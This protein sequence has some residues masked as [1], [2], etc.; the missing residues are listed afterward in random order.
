VTIW[1]ERVLIGSESAPQ[2]LTTRSLAV[3]STVGCTV[4]EPFGDSHGG[5]SSH[6]PRAVIQ[7]VAKAIVDKRLVIAATDGSGAVSSTS[8]NLGVARFE[9]AVLTWINAA[10]LQGG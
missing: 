8:R 2:P 6:C 3:T 1:G 5:R 10:P 4:E 9:A 7:T